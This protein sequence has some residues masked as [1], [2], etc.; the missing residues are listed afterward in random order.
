MPTLGG[1]NVP[2]QSELKRNQNQTFTSLAVS[3]GAV[4]CSDDRGPS[5]AISVQTPT[6]QLLK[7]MGH[8]MAFIIK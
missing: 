3:G 2:E 4:L 7:S 6:E 5:R 1:E 8:I